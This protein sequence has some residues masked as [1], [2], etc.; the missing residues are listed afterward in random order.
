[1]KLKAYLML[2]RVETLICEDT[3]EDNLTQEKNKEKKGKKIILKTVFLKKQ[4]LKKNFK[5]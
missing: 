3:F 2:H 5:T 4:K 1:M